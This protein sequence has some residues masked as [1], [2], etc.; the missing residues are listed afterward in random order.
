M[1]EQAI[2]TIYLLGEQPDLLCSQIIKNLTAAVFTPSS[3]DNDN[4]AAAEATEALQDDEARSVPP[5]PARTID[6]SAPTPYK[7]SR[8]ESQESLKNDHAGSFPL[9]QLVFVVGH[10]A[11]KHIVYLELVERE[12]K[13][14][15]DETAKRECPHVSSRD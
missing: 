14:R 6:M 4:H 1:A 8:S 7:I 2:N 9:A 11:I 3:T 13:R 12:F 10:V 5:T 15:K